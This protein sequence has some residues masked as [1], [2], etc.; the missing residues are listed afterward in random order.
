MLPSLTSQLTSSLSFSLIKQWLNPI[1]RLKHMTEIRHRPTW[2]IVTKPRRQHKCAVLPW[3][4][5]HPAQTT[6]AF[7][8]SCD[9]SFL[10]T[11]ASAWEKLKLR[12]VGWSYVSG[13]SVPGYYFIPGVVVVPAYCPFLDCSGLGFV[14][15]IFPPLLNLQFAL[16]LSYS[17]GTYTDPSLRLQLTL[18]QKV[19]FLP[20]FVKYSPPVPPPPLPKP[21]FALAHSAHAIPCYTWK[22]L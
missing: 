17:Y 18:S 7:P 3:A 4:S 20:V 22:S 11:A 21:C 1:W 16:P 10:I 2:P 8:E 14:L 13:S 19:S 12:Y 9:V 6:R 5:L 15:K